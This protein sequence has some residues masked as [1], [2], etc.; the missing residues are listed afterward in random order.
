MSLMKKFQAAVA[1]T[2]QG[3]EG[4]KGKTETVVPFRKPDS[5][6]FM[7]EGRRRSLEACMDTT[8]FTLMKEIQAGGYWKPGPEIE[9]LEREVHATYQ[10]VLRGLKRLSDYRN[11]VERWRKAG[12]VH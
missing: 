11:Q 1:A 12:T 2:R 8:M 3:D 9:Q 4:V 5:P 10:A 6:E 7:T